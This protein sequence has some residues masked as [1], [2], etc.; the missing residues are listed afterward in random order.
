MRI[1]G[2]KC[3]DNVVLIGKC[4]FLLEM[5][6]EITMIWFFYVFFGEEEPDSVVVIRFYLGA[7]FLLQFFFFV[8]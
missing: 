2:H 8:F 5:V 3:F 4:H 1:I 6:E 7:V